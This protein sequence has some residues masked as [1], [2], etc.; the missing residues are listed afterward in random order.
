MERIQGVNPWKDGWEWT[1]V[2]WISA[3]IYWLFSAGL[4]YLAFKWPPGSTTPKVGFLCLGLLMAAGGFLLRR[5]RLVVSP[6]KT[7]LTRESGPWAGFGQNRVTIPLANQRYVILRWRM[8][9]AV[10]D[11][12]AHQI[13]HRLLIQDA[14]GREDDLFPQDALPLGAEK[15]GRSLASFLGI[16]FRVDGQKV[17]RGIEKRGTTAGKKG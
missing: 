10:A 4:I 16:E 17:P 7:V 1:Y 15:C 11:N 6:D 9:L 3:I 14:E 8:S 13:S 5:T 2:P 12:S